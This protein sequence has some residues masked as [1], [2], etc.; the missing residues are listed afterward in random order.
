MQLCRTA[1]ATSDGLY[2][3]SLP[4]VVDPGDV[5]R[6]GEARLGARERVV[7]EERRLAHVDVYGLRVPGGADAADDDERA[8]G[9]VVVEGVGK[10]PGVA[11][12]LHDVGEGRPRRKR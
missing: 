5:E 10:R 8:R 11:P 12:R 1:E 2:A 9:R 4:P 3:A 6:V 7:L